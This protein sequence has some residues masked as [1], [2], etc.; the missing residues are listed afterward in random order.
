MADLLDEPIRIGSGVQEVAFEAVQW[1]DG[2]ADSGP[3]CIFRRRAQMVDTPI[4]LVCGSAAA[5]E[6][7]DGRVVRSH[8]NLAAEIDRP[9]D[10]A[11]EVIERGRADSW[12]VRD[13]A[14]IG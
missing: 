1:L 6:V 8:E 4:P 3:G 14:R 5:G 7:A 9:V 2:E 13:R 11:L 10:V 12:I